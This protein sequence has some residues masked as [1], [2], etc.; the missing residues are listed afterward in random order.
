MLFGHAAPNDT[1][2]T[3]RHTCNRNTN[4]IVNTTTT[5]PQAAKEQ[6]GIHECILRAGEMLFVPRGWWHLAL[7]LEYSIAVTQNLVSPV[8]LPHTAA[9]LSTRSAELVSGLAEGARGELYDHLVEALKVCRGGGCYVRGCWGC[10]GGL[11]VCMCCGCR[12]CVLFV[13]MFPCIMTTAGAS[14][15]AVSGVGAA[16][17]FCNQEKASCCTA[18]AV[19][20][21]GWVI[22]EQ[23]TNQHVDWIFIWFS[24]VNY[25]QTRNHTLLVE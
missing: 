7:N 8:T 22:K 10:G 23:K 9:F 18:C 15:A 6:H 12:C 17:A 2:T 14:R 11:Y 21:R 5:T 19:R 25:D 4:P 1:H 24:I 16:G 20:G 13:H 3:Q